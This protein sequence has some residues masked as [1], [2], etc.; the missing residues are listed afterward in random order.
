[1]FSQRS[2]QQGPIIFHPEI[3]SSPNKIFDAG[4][5]LIE[6]ISRSEVLFMKPIL[7]AV[8]GRRMYYRPFVFY[9]E[10]EVDGGLFVGV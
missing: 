6:D 2:K 3:P 8:S 4:I 9:T 1:M 5:T 10:E 7:I